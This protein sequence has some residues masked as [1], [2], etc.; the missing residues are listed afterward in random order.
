MTS[1]AF[2]HAAWPTLCVSPKT[3]IVLKEAYQPIV[4]RLR[5]VNQSED[6]TVRWS[7]ILVNRKSTTPFGSINSTINRTTYRGMPFVPSI[8]VDILMKGYQYSVDKYLIIT[9]AVQCVESHIEHLFDRN[10]CVCPNQIKSLGPQ[11]FYY[12]H[13]GEVETLNRIRKLPGSEIAKS[14]DFW[15]RSILNQEITMISGPQW[16]VFIFVVGEFF[17]QNIS[18]NDSTSRSNVYSRLFPSCRPPSCSHPIPPF[19][20]NLSHPATYFSGR[21]SHPICYHG[22]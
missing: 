4:P 3:N 18:H 9:S 20:P 19:A 22:L 21:H 1:K 14:A 12:W 8:C 6:Q 10:V 11:K 15:P 7:K 13:E 5:T 17:A 2:I 16:M